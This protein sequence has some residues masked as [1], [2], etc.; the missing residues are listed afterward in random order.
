MY[1]PWR[2]RR[3][4]IDPLAPIWELIFFSLQATHVPVMKS[5]TTKPA[6]AKIHMSMPPT[7]NE[8]QAPIAEPAAM[9]LNS[10][11]VYA[12]LSQAL[13]GFKSTTS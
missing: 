4:F 3:F 8:K 1:L 11:R 13:R 12:F 10:V 6:R 9:S 5:A 2:I 7:A